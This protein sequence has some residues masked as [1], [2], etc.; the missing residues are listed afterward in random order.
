[1]AD[2]CVV[3][4]RPNFIGKVVVAGDVRYKG[5]RVLTLVHMY[6]AHRNRPPHFEQAVVIGV[7]TRD[8]R[9]DECMLGDVQQFLRRRNA[10]LLCGY[11]TCPKEQVLQLCRLCAAAG[12][13]P[14]CQMFCLPHSPIDRQ[15]SRALALAYNVP[16]FPAKRYMANPTY[17]MVLGRCP[18]VHH[19][20]DIIS[21]P[22]LPS[23]L[24]SKRLNDLDDIP[25]WS[26]VEVSRSSGNQ[27]ASRTS[28]WSDNSSVKQKQTNVA[29]WCVG[30]H[31]LSIS[32]DDRSACRQGRDALIRA[33]ARDCIAIAVAALDT[34]EIGETL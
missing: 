4:Y 32:I 1:M 15:L 20:G 2:L 23:W 27:H 10:Q 8:A 18:K 24:R 25:L 12:N 21:A 17:A 26:D 31:K 22:E 3:L 33:V 7:A 30:I 5:T 28:V 19:A 11:F 14:F 13:R 9:F 6:S 16:Q 34:I 29:D